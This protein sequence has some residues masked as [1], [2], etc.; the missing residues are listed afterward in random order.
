MTTEQE[1]A[2]ATILIVDDNPFNVDLL[3]IYLQNAGFNVVMAEDGAGGLEQASE[4][5][6]DLILLDIMMPGL[7]GFETCRRLKEDEVTRHIPVIFMTAL[8]KTSEK[9]KAFEVGGVDY[10]TKPFEYP[11]VLARINTHLSIRR[12]QQSLQEQNAR[13]QQENIMRRR[14][15]DALQE[16]RQ[17][18]R[19]LA[20]YSTDM[21]S[22]Q[23]PEGIFRYVSPACRR[24]LGYEIEEMIGRPMYDFF[25]PDDLQAIQELYQV[26]QKWP[27]EFTITYRARR[28]DGSYI[29]LET[30]SQTIPD[31]KTGQD[32]E[33]IAVSRNVTERIQAEEALKEAR[34]ELERRVE[35]RTAELAQANV[36]LKDEIAERKRVELEL[37]A[38]S[39]EL[40]ATNEALAHLDKLKDEFL[41]NTSHELR[42]PLNGI[43]GIAESMLDGAAGSL[44]PKQ[45][46]NLSIVV[47]SGRKLANLVNDILDFAKL[48]HQ[49]ID[50]SLKAVDMRAVTE[51]VFTLA[52]PL[53]NRKGLALLNQIPPDVPLAKADESRIQQVMHNL[54]GNAIKFTEEGSITVTAAVQADMLAITVSDTGIG[55][56]AHKFESI[57]QSFEQVDASTTRTYGGTGLG[58]SISKQL[59][60]LH[61]GT[62]GVQSELGQGTRFTFT[63]PLAGER[64]REEVDQRTDTGLVRE[65]IRLDVDEILMPSSAELAENKD[66]TV[67]VVDDDLVNVQVLTNYLTLQNYGVVQAFDG[68]EAL[69]A[70]A[71]VSADLVLLDIM[72]PRMSGYEVCQKIRADHPANELPIVLLTAKD[73]IKDLVAGFEA[74]ANDYLTKPV[75]KNELLARVKTHL[76]LAKIN[77]A[78]GRFVPHE[79]LRFLHKES[80]VDVKLGDQVRSEMTILFTD[81]RSFTTLSESMTPQENFNFLNAYL[82]RVSP[83]IRQH[84]G[85]IDKYIGDAVMALFPYQA[86]DALEA[87]IAMGQ[88]LAHY[89]RY[90]QQHD[91][92]PIEVGTG[93]HTGYLMLGTIGEAKRM[94]GTVISDA[95]NLASR[96][97]GLT[98]LYGASII[99]SQHSLFSL[100]QPTKYHF[101]FLDRVQVKGKKEPVS[102]FEIFNGDPEHIIE[103]KLKTNT[104]FEK[105]LLFYHSQ[106]FVAAKS[107]FE[108]VLQQNPADSAA[109]LYLQRT[110]YFM[111]YGVPPHWEGIEAI[112]EKF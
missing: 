60:E 8:T 97:E 6:P 103:L 29:W 42:T 46:Y 64:Q 19:L 87:A 36:I 4:T 57:F 28:K 13:L 104:D 96:L 52:Q 90:R 30:T 72:M 91:R 38:Y 95:V 5:K 33:I 80:I 58:L 79:L 7:D 69:E 53:A 81:I 98:K 93:I 31:P 75:D 105:G 71:E 9:V 3:S 107:H 24:L 35:E 101:R 25:H 110:T 27:T 94:E 40:K 83:L 22:Q 84:H 89:N 78:Y 112:N 74:G 10:I 45:M 43:I 18:Y 99:V 61:G 15:L 56:P 102:V 63:L 47:S 92:K 48:K 12:L 62:I 108:Q 65:R 59:V 50:L 100:S 39:E 77:T 2:R 111:E 16:S 55:I 109:Q 86:E 82:G 26:T 1:Q 85:F 44:S 73:Q 70:L 49:E 54:V 11:E 37:Q 20:E 17:R 41:A 14:V 32:L 21:I 88:E 66:F 23:T 67:L 51:I 106:E 76:R 34:N 68:F